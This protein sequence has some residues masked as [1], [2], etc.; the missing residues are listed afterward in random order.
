A[1][2]QGREEGGK[3][4]QGR[5]ILSRRAHLRLVLA[6]CPASGTRRRDQGERDVQ[7]RPSDRDPP[8][9]PGG[10]EHG[11]SGQ[12]RVAMVVSRATLEG[13]RPGS[14]SRA[15]MHWKERS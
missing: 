15:S 11:H 9:D 5:K 1:D 10:S 2:R 12:D 7:E 14:A 3:G 4:G 13:S 8:E 6:E